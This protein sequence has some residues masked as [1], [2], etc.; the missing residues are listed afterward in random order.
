MYTKVIKDGFIIG[1]GIAQIDPIATQK[2]IADDL[3]KSDEYKNLVNKKKTLKSIHTSINRSLYDDNVIFFKA[4]KRM[5]MSIEEMA[6]M[7]RLAPSEAEAKLNSSEISERK[8]LVEK[9]QTKHAESI[10][11]M[12]TMKEDSV[13][14]EKKR[15]GLVRSKAVYFEDSKYEFKIDDDEKT[16]IENKLKTLKNGQM[17]KEDMTIYTKPKETDGGKAKS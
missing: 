17:L 16:A 9:I 13:N 15:K 2:N 6:T 4:A 11:L 14:L 3:D 5:K 7:I 12:G 1:I 8:N 10:A